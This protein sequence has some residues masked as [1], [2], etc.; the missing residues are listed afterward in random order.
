LTIG[1]HQSY[2]QS[3]AEARQNQGIL[4]DQYDAH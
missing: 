2:F 4:G 1:L 3:A